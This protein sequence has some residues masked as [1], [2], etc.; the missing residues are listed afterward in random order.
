M[1]RLRLVS[2]FI[3]AVLPLGPF[4]VYLTDSSYSPALVIF[5][6]AVTGLLAAYGLAAS[7][8]AGAAGLFSMIISSLL[9]MFGTGYIPYLAG[10]SLGSVSATGLVW[11]GISIA[12][13]VY[14]YFL[15]NAYH[16]VT[17]LSR[18]LKRMNYEEHDIAELGKLNSSMIAVGAGLLAISVLAYEVIA[19]V[20]LT[21][22]KNSLLALV[23]FLGGYAFI[24]IAVRRRAQ[25]ARQLDAVR[26]NER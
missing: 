2:G 22:L 4:V 6:M 7:S 14:A 26:V 9:L 12:G 21:L 1:V 10:F 5:L 19:Y 15:G 13:S 23:V 18:T 17:R 3:A 8:R 25:G 20:R 24:M 11:L 16:S